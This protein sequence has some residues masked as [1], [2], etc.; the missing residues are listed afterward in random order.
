ME[1]LMRLLAVAT[2]LATLL[3]G[4][5]TAAHGA[6][7][8]ANDDSAKHQ[9]DRGAA[10]YAQMEDVGLRQTVI[11][12]RFVP[13]EA[14]VIQDKP[15]LDE[16]IPN[17]VEA[18]L[19][20][21]L[22]VY[23]Y[24]PREIEE[25][26]GSPSLFGSYV[27]ALASIYPQ[28]R[29]FVIG[30]EPNQPAFWRPQF[31]A[32]GKNVSA[33]A[34]GPYLAA[35]YDALDAV[36][37]DLSVVG[38]GLSPRGN[39][40]PQA[41]NNISTSPVRFLR[42]LGAWYRKSGRT[43]P[44]MD[45][46]SLHPYPNQATDT[47]DRGYAWPNVGFA[48]L[49]RIKQ[50]LWDAFH[51]TPQPTTV[52]G[53][54]LHLDEVGWQVDTSD[55]PGYRGSEN[56]PVTDEVT[57]AAIYGELVRRAACDPDVAEVS[58]FGFRDDGLRTGF[59]AALYRAD[60]SARPSAETVRLAIAETTAGCAGTPEQWF[61]AEQVMGARVDIGTRTSHV[62]ARIGAGEDARGTVC[63]RAF[64]V[65]AGGAPQRVTRSCRKLTVA[66]LKPLSLAFLSTSSLVR[67]Q[68]VADLRAES[69]AKRRTVVVQEAA[70][71][72]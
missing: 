30:N 45:A 3:L 41:K 18:G 67:V 37:P 66:G 65:R 5:A 2:A 72:R 20:V 68:V 54:K 52:E 19:D 49:D 61:P 62:L 31:D 44:L 59:Q 70:L 27:G 63:V 28:V 71:T 16:V 40:R 56:V 22:A 23:P 7:V 13:S 33:A 35:A 38:V 1:H 10:M 55:R 21:V 25:G 6:S 51:G 11:G 50:A 64:H 57:Q 58:F 9:D 32:S 60:G 47:L 42:S 15:L 14:I 43:R 34:F 8:G 4:G 26:L 36:D 48:N 39:D 17:A 53:L 12:V 46:F 29:T 24:P 69:N